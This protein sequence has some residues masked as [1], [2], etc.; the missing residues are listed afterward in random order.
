[1]FVVKVK[2]KD[3]AR[4]KWDIFEII[5]ASP[6]PDESLELIQPTKAENACSF[7]T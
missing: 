1:M 4:D 3:K 6:G 5:E 7:A 2:E